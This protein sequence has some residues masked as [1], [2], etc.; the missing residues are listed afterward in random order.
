M[1]YAVKQRPP[2][3]GGDAIQQRSEGRAP[4]Q[5]RGTCISSSPTGP[6]SDSTQVETG[7]RLWNPTWTPDGTRITAAFEDASQGVWVDPVTGAVEPFP[8]SQLMW[9]PRQRPVP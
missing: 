4:R 1:G 5:T 8:T 6:V 9:R 7:R 2:A 3:R